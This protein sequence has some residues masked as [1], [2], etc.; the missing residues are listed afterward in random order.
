MQTYHWQNVK[1]A[2]IS[3][4]GGLAVGLAKSDVFCEVK[5]HK[6][7]SRPAADSSNWGCKV[8]STVPNILMPL[9]LKS[10]LFL[11]SRNALNSLISR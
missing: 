4:A 5:I 3:W 11:S 7:F 10:F 2:N 9:I 6:V 8:L 1:K